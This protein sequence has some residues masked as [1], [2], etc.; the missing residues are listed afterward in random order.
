ME[1]YETLFAQLKNRQEGAFVPFVTLGDPGPEQSLKIID[2]LIEGGA[3]AL[4][5]GIPFSDPLA[6]GPTIQGAA[7]RAFAAGVTPAQCFEMLAAI[8]QKHPT[9]PIG[10]LMYANL[11]FSPGI[12]AF[13][14]Q[15]AR[16]GVDSVLVADVPVEES[17][18][19]RQA[20]MRHNIAPIFICPPNADDDLLRQIASYG[21]GYTYLLSRAV[22]KLAEYHAA[23]P[24][25]GFGISAP[26]QVSAAIDAGAVGAI[27]GSAIV[28]IIER[29]LDEPQT[30]LDELKAFVQSLKAATKTA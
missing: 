10:L 30:M 1:R 29:H 6:D 13:Y 19:F 4:E 28:K 9:I 22:E 16:V 23:P 5:L 24:L 15:C 11:V 12:D 2:A 20:A 14:A 27:S 18:P 26:E 7:L 25:Q 8:R 21:R 3:D 17:A